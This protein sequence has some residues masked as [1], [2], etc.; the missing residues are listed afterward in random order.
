MMLIQ[1][2][3]KNFKSFRD[4]A[5]LDL[6]AARVTEFNNRVI[7]IGNE[8]VLPVAAIFGANASGKSNIQQAFS[9]MLS[10]VLRSF[11]FGGD[12]DEKKAKSEFMCPAPF[13]FDKL[14]K[15]EP[16]LFEVYFISDDSDRIRQYNYGFSI[17][18]KGVCEEWLNVCA[19]S[20][21]GKFKPIFYRNRDHEELD[22]TGLP[23][24]SQE[25]IRTALE[26]ETLIVSLGAKLKIK[27]FKFIRDWF[28]KHEIVNFGNPFE[29][30]SFSKYLPEG[31]SDDYNIRKKVVDF[32]SSFDESIIDFEVEKLKDDDDHEHITIKSV[33]R[34]TES[35]DTI[36]LPLYEESAGTLKM[37]ALYPSFQEVMENGG[38][39]FVDELNSRLHPL[40]VRSFLI[41]FLDPK[42]NKHHAQII[43][44]SH[45]SWILSNNSLRRDEVWF[46]EK[47]ENDVSSLYSLYDFVDE[48]GQKIRKDE[49][50]EKNYLLG[51]YGA[52]PDLKPMMVM[53]EDYGKGS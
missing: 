38:V 25:N 21:R 52:I 17:D 37:L 50:Y 48:M 14:S 23:K 16:S 5:T 45:E 13:L 43:F 49:S 42:I 22:L 20:A 35:N 26:N 15:E 28:L 46:T 36:S 29:D 44:T 4:Q 32:V 51:K 9:Y 12:S 7:E 19:K 11:A 10:Y 47:D 39:L 31:F 30:L 41:N 3:F 40:L 1:F 53:E 18:H 34:I 24:N 6:S 33:H 27:E 8:K 2:N